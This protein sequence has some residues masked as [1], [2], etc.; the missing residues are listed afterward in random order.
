MSGNHAGRT[1]RLARRHL[2]IDPR[3]N[4]AARRRPRDRTDVRA[5]QRQ[6]C[7]ILPALPALL[8]LSALEMAIGQRYVTPGALV[9]HSDQGVQYACGD[10]IARLER[11]SIQ[12]SM[13]RPGCPGLSMGQCDGR[14]FLMDIKTRRGERPSVSRS[15]R[16]RSLDYGVCRDRIQPAAIAFGA[17]LRGT[18]RLRGR[19]FSSAMS[20]T[21]G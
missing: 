10:Y 2:R 19:A 16:R 3:G 7:R 14:E 1:A 4:A 13:S 9:H 6:P 15:G 12:P 11:A 8:A 20:G 21:G 17:G 5:G 18:G